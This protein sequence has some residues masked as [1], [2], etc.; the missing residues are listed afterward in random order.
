MSRDSQRFLL[1]AYDR[2]ACLA[3]IILLSD[4]QSNQWPEFSMQSVMIAQQS[5]DSDPAAACQ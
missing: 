3:A 1:G 5:G 2:R 4:D